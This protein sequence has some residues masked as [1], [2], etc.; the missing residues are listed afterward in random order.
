M[1]ALVLTAVAALDVVADT[2][3]WAGSAAGGVW[4]D[5]ENW[6][7]VGAAQLQDFRRQE[8][9]TDDSGRLQRA[10]DATRGGILY[11][12]MGSY[13]IA[14]T[15][16]VSNGCA[17]ALH[18]NARLVA[19]ADMDYVLRIANGGGTSRDCGDFITGGVIDG[20]GRA[21]C[22]SVDGCWTLRI[23]GVRLLDPK[24][25][26]LHVASG[27]ARVLAKGIRVL[28][29][30]KGLGGNTG[31]FLEGDN[32]HYADIDVRECT[33]G[34]RIGGAANRL[35]G[36]RAKGGSRTEMLDGSTGFLIEG[37][38]TILRECD[39]DT[40]SVGFDV[41]AAGETRLLGCAWRCKAGVGL[42]DVVIVRRSGADGSLLVSDGVFTRASAQQVRVCDGAGEV[43]WRDILY[44]G[45]WSGVALPE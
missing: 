24:T 19:A 45:D 10:V 17:L 39:V 11:V 27:G 35:A 23:E 31:L 5:P 40:R 7:A 9:E 21:G 37:P 4:E 30:A 25:C 3:T 2:L 18:Q 20:R 42:D 6:S 26:G 29:Q 43:R 33:T 36:V 8:G 22:L 14:S 13:R 44:A 1:F 34:V 12:P 41:R 16:T 15:V 28:T 32:G 38:G